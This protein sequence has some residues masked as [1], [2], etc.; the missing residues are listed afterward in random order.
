[1]RALAFACLPL[2][3]CAA[4]LDDGSL[5]RAAQLPSIRHVFVITMENHDPG[6]IYGSPDAPYLNGTLLPAGAHATHFGDEL[7]ASVPSEP[8]YVWMEAGTNVFPDHT[9]TSDLSPGW[10][11]NTTSSTQHLSTQLEHA[12]LSW[13]S[14]QEGLN[15]MTG[16]CPVNDWWWYAAKHDPF[17]FFQDVS[18]SSPSASN[19]H[20][21]A[22]H[23]ELGKLAGDLAS[24]AVASYVFITPDLCHD[25]HGALFCPDSNPVHA[26]DTWMHDH[27][28]A[29]LDYANRN[30]GLVL[31]VWDEGEGTQTMPFLAL[32]PDVKPGYTGDVVYTHSSQL[33]TVEE[34]FG[35]PVLPTVAS[36]NDLSDL[37][38]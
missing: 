16:A 10:F 14:Y 8:H 32:G 26:G 22:H 30:D 4:D 9:F 17:V 7:P 29:I 11:W 20:C 1:M 25:M 38:Y 21:A 34:L 3:A 23:Q 6:A 24:G 12:G 5:D 27:L 15:G 28:P 33:K 35:L 2:V 36:A 19:A 31:I 37:F 13:M 18:G